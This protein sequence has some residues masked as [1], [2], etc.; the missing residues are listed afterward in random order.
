MVNKAKPVCSLL[1]QRIGHCDKQKT[2]PVGLLAENGLRGFSD[3]HSPGKSTSTRQYK[4]RL[5]LGE[6][7]NRFIAVPSTSEVLQYYAIVAYYDCS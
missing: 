6:I 2:Y 5:E 7:F 1:I 3:A 4:S